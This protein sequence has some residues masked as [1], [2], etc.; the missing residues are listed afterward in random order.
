MIK[1]IRSLSNVTGVWDR[2]S[3]AG[4]AFG[5]TDPFSSCFTI[6]SI[7]KNGCPVS[8]LHQSGHGRG[9][10]KDRKLMLAFFFSF[11]I[12]GKYLSREVTFGQ[13]TKAHHCFWKYFKLISPPC[14]PSKFMIL[15]ARKKG[16]PGRQTHNA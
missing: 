11:H 10:V 4:E 2:W 3:K 16:D 6:L 7:D 14:L 9:Q 13:W 15:L 5:K 12:G 1:Q 8:T